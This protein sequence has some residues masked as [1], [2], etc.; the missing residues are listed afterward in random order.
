[1]A[2]SPA[3]S[4]YPRDILADT[5][6][7][8]TEQF[9]AYSKLLAVAW[10]GV[11]GSPQGYLPADEDHL[12]KLAGLTAAR[13]R[14]IGAPVLALFKRDDSGR[15]FHKRLLA[16]IDRQQQ[17]SESARGSARRRW[18]K[19]ADSHTDRTS[20]AM[21]THC[22]GNAARE[23]ADANADAKLGKREREGER[24]PPGDSG[25]WAPYRRLLA[26]LYPAARLPGSEA[27]AAWEAIDA[28]L[29]EV[30]DRGEL[31]AALEFGLVLWQWAHSDDWAQE[32]G[33]F[34]PAPEVWIRRD[35]RRTPRR[36]SAHLVDPGGWRRQAEVVELLGAAA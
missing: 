21:R 17:R 24:V 12:P 15:L 36:F 8:T 20:S 35:C 10:L 2:K 27:G 9:G 7:L 4:Y 34:V 14:K 1:M 30:A 33:R 26:G 28:A 16:E 3:F 31:P 29:L 32:E 5:L 18:E 22:V 19:G 11:E 13:W 6:H 23:A 25:R